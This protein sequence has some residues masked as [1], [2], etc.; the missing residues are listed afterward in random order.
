MNF[1]I[2]TSYF[3]LQQNKFIKNYLINFDNDSYAQTNYSINLMNDKRVA[4]WAFRDLIRWY[5][6]FC[7]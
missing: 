5:F 3:T 4:F 2:L 6:I 1:V 7:A